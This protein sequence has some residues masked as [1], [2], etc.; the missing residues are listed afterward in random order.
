MNSSYWTL[1][2]HPSSKNKDW[3]ADSYEFI[4]RIHNARE[5][6]AMLR[7]LTSQRAVNS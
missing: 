6:V 5:L 2:W 7:T 1:Y 4:A 3:S